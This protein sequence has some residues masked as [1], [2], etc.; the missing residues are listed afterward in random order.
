MD[1]CAGRDEAKR[2][3]AVGDAEAAGKIFEGGDPL[4]RAGLPDVGLFGAGG[5]GVNDVEERLDASGEEEGG[6]AGGEIGAANADEVEGGG[7]A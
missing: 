6:D 7:K 4:V 2:R 1:A 5:G 3:G